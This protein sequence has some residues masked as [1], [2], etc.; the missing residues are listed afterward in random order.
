MYSNSIFLYKVVGLCTYTSLCACHL[1]LWDKKRRNAKYSIPSHQDIPIQFFHTLIYSQRY[2]KKL[3]SMNKVPLNDRELDS[4]K[5]PIINLQ[6]YL[7]AQK[8]ILE[9][10]A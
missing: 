2:T 6:S 8:R 10:A 3:A 1:A 7:K 4:S 5:G 9:T